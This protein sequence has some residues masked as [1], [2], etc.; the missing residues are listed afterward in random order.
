VNAAP[1]VVL[2]HGLWFGPWS[3]APLAQRLRRA[4]FEP[5]RF[6]YRTTT[7]ALDQHARDLR[8]FVGPAPQTP[9][10]FVAHSLGGLVTLQMLAAYPDLPAGRVV[11]LG[12]PLRGSLA[13][14]K[15]RRVPG[16]RRLLGAARPTL[17]SG[18]A[19]PAPGR[20]IGREIGMIAGSRGIGLGLLLGGVGGPGD[21]TVAVAETRAE[22][23]ADHRVLPVTH[24]GLLFSRAVARQAC[25]FLQNGRFDPSPL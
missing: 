24:T 8:A 15:A 19:G 13:A 9:L 20:E 5:R 12:S 6:R 18:I 7:A 14:R 10:H 16:G 22:G 21:G 3:L 25:H 2:V 4:G 23:L 17:E 1:Q 11:L